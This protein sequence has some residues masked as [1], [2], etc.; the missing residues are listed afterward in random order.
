[1]PRSCAKWIR[2]RNP[3]DRPIRADATSEQRAALFTSDRLPGGVNGAISEVV[4]SVMAHARQARSQYTAA[5][6]VQ[7]FPTLVEDAKP[8]LVVHPA[9][10]DVSGNAARLGRIYCVERRSCPVYEMTTRPVGRCGRLPRSRL[11]RRRRNRAR[12][13]IRIERTKKILLSPR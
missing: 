11:S 3:L 8:N 6:C 4:P 9:A 13:R 7:W 1:L 2:Q 12:S 10:T 5:W